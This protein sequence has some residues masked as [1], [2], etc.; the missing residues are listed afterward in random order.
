MK[1]TAILA[2]ALLFLTVANYLPASELP[3]TQG[4]RSRS[5]RVGTFPQEV[6]TVYRFPEGLPDNDVR[7]VAVLPDGRVFAG[8]AKGL[9]RLNGDRWTRVNGIPETPVVAL[10]EKGADL[11]VVTAKSLYN[12]HDGTVDRLA[13]VPPYTANGVA[14]RANGTVLLGTQAGLF[15]LAGNEFRPVDDLN[16]MLGKQKDVRQ[17]AVGPDGQVV[18]AAMS[19][20]FARMNG[21]WTQFTPRDGDRSWAPYDVRGVAYDTRGRLWFA[22]VQG[23]GCFD[24]GWQLFTGTEGLP[25]DDF[26]TMAVGENG[27]VWFGTHIGAIRHDGEQWL[28]RQGRRWL[29]DDEVRAIAVSGD[30]TA[31]F[32]TPNGVG[33]IERRPMTLAEKARHY[34]EIIDKRHRRTPYGYVLECSL[35]RPGD[36]SEWS[37]HDSDNDGLWTA[38]YG[39]GECFAY[40]AT[41]SDLARKRA[42]KA[43]EALRFLSEVPQGDEKSPPPGFPAR[44]IL[45]TSGP[46]PNLTQYTIEKDKRRRQTTDPLWKVIWPR[47]P[48]SADGKW[49]WKCDTSSDELDGHY[50]FN[51]VYYDLVAETDDEKEAVRKVIL[52]TTDHLIDHGFYLVDWDGKPTRWGVFAPEQLN[53]NPFWYEERG[54]NSLSMLSYLAVAEHVSG[55]PKYRRVADTLIKDHSYHLN[56]FIAKMHEGPGTGNQSDDEMAIMGFYN[57]VNYETDPE[58]SQIYQVAFR[59]YWERERREKNPFF[60]FAFGG[61]TGGKGRNPW[62]ATS[63]PPGFGLKDALDTLVRMPLDLINWPLR[64]SH[65]KDI[66]PH[67][68][69]RVR[70]GQAPRVGHLRDG[71]VL[72]VDNRSFNHWNHNPWQLDYSGD[73]MTEADGAIFLLPYYMG[74]YHGF[75][76]EE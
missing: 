51:A 58:L 43:F 74:L 57:L 11:L 16:A 4:V 63:G 40:A 14:V 27:V 42:T 38:M 64:N 46:N 73:G 41:G 35:A 31:W 50:F 66:V 6:S 54:L 10:G 18:V 21:S 20:L 70:P 52:A 59:Q 12:L 44:S 67:P 13:A 8:T 55:D 65:R 23:A 76:V 3:S 39:A 25:Y 37:N 1:K 22:S 34:E 2:T 53:H 48:K 7:S 9:A 72:P 30:G 71:Y 19:G 36:T 68:A 26:T 75:I 17:V 24:K 56:T 29:P 15:E 5:I 33:S 28:Y 49:Y 69:Y 47:W 45:P 61:A 62:G 32:A 60:N